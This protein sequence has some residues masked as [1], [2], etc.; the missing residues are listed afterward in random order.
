MY[1]AKSY[2]EKNFENAVFVDNLPLI[3]K[4]NY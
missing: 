2:Y 3:S 4:N 1:I